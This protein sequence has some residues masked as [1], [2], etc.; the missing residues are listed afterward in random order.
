MKRT[1]LGF[2]LAALLSTVARADFTVTDIRVEG[3]QRIPEGTVFNLLP[4]NIGDMLGPQ[5]VREA[6]RAVHASGFFRDVELRREEPGVLV[7]V[8]QEFPSI[9]AFEITG[10]KIIKKEDLEKSLRNVGLASGKLFNRSTLE[11]VRQYLV[12]QYYSRGHYDVRVDTKVEELSGNLVD[13]KLTVAENKRAK[14]RQI[15]VVGNEKFTDK[16]LLGI[17]ELKPTNLLSFYRGDD[18]YSRESLTGDLEKIRSYYMDRGYANFEIT[19]TQVAMAPEKDDLFVTVNVFEGT[20][21]RMG[22]IKLAGRFVVPQVILQ[23]YVRIKTGDTFSRRL[24][25][26]SEE[27][28]RNRLS[29]EGFS[30]ADVAAVPSIDPDTGEIALTFQIEP[31]SRTYVRRVTFLGVEK[32]NDTVLRREMRQLEG[33]VMSN[34]LVT[35]SE[36]RLQRLPYITSVES[37]TKPVAGSPDL[38]DVEVKIEEGPSSQ[39]GGGIGYSERQSVMLSGNFVDS[40]LLGTGRRLAVELNGGQYSKVFSVAHTDPYFTTDGMSLSLNGGYVER[41]RL[42]ASFSQFETKTYSTGFSLGYPLSENQGVNFG[43]SYSHEDLATV[44]SSST[45]LRDW[46]RNNGDDYFRRIG[47]DSVLGTIL[48]V[49]EFNVGWGYDS[50][51]RTLFPTRGGQYRFGFSVTPPVTSVSYAIARFQS[52]Q[53]FRIPLP[54]IDRMPFM[55]ST[56]LGYGTAFGDTTAVPPHRHIFTGGSDSVRGFRDGTLG[57]R[58]SLG[59]PY[60]GDAGVSAQLEAI[61]PLPAKFATSAR[62]SLFVDA[63]QSYYLGDTQFRNRRGDRTDYKFDLGD[64]RVSAGVGIQWLSP[65]GLFRFSYAQP[66]KYQSQTRREFGDEIERFQFSVGTAF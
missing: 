32:T 62:L 3:L 47:R 29:D 45:Q 31:N 7:V 55:L 10:N 2:L 64:L 4:V 6:L 27:A 30:F 60:G 51:D 63:G 33:A 12:E 26:L 42:T 40:N 23:Q 46:V 16:E 50:R 44:S 53:F 39:L 66:L 43:L 57:P 49:V 56:D 25:S 1:G 48:D 18:K 38:V 54:L 37:E 19:S 58:D 20:T 61:I 34:G 28:I 41:A 11:D 35:R 13:V 59:N 5:R 24:I 36:E 22:A 15:N 52:Q 65:M 14:I 21:Y 17:T 8:V 9:R